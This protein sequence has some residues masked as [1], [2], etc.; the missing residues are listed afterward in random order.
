[1]TL[2]MCVHYKCGPNLV[3]SVIVKTVK[4]LGH[5]LKAMITHVGLLHKHATPKHRKGCP[6]PCAH[7]TYVGYVWH[8]R[9]TSYFGNMSSGV[10]VYSGA[11]V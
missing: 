9:S 11:H 10:K 2:E 8:G 5:L 6:D 7:Y 1:M 3:Q 4:D